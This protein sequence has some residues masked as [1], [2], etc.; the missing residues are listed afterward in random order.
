MSN[1]FIAP[2]SH[3]LKLLGY[4]S[5]VVLFLAWWGIPTIKKWQADK[6]VDELCTQ[7][8]GNKIYEVVRLSAD[9]FDLNGQAVLPPSEKHIQKNDNY[10]YDFSIKNIIGNSNGPHINDLVIWRSET[11]IVRV[12]DKKVMATLISYTRRGG[13]PIGPWHPSYYTCQNNGFPSSVFIKQ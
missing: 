12:T 13:D 1:K 9:N 6:L 2:I 10:Y 4:I 11:K 7:N 8:G 5:F 3:H